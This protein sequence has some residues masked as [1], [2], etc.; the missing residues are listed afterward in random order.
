MRYLINDDDLE[1]ALI[2]LLK[3]IHDEKFY[4]VEWAIALL[5]SASLKDGSR[6][7]LKLLEDIAKSSIRT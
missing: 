6:P 2:E 1:N 3:C 4:H 5:S 7:D